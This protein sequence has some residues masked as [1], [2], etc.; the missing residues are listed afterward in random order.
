M[1][2]TIQAATTV[3]SANAN[4]TG[5]PTDN[6]TA[7]PGFGLSRA[8][9]ANWPMDPSIT[10]LNHGSYGLCPRAVSEAQS[11]LRA[12]MERDPVRFFKV[13]LE[14]LMDGVRDRLGAYLNC[15]AADLAPVM[16]A[17]VAL[18]TILHNTPFQAGDE[19]LVTDHE[20]SSGLNELARM[21]PKLGIKVVT[22]KVSFPIYSPREVVDS[23]LAAV[24]PR[25]KLVLISQ[26][27][28][29]TSLIFP[30]EL[31][32]AELNRRNID[33][34]VDGAH[35]PGQIAVDIAALQP[36]YWVG[37]FHKWA[38]APKGTSFMYVRPDKQANFRSVVLSSRA[39]KVRPE[40]KLFL[41]DFDYMGTA[42]Y[43]GLLTIPVA[44]DTMANLLPGGLPALM[45]HNHSMVIQARD[46]VTRITGL[47]PTA[48]DSMTGCMTTLILPSPDAEHAARPTIYDDPMQ[49]AL[50]DR[51]RIQIP[52]WPF[53]TGPGQPGSASNADLRLLRISAQ[54]YNTPDEYQKLGEA[55][56]QELARER[57][58]RRTG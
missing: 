35:A 50:L 16:N 55:L 36:T 5:S 18:A 58:L 51:H 26:I 4:P 19:V 48:P 44:L 8:A 20:Y 7:S 38:S 14:R 9:R 29:A 21:A 1:T 13:D 28:S 53:G 27:T 12:R 40:R 22:A 6:L 52:V 33:V 57:T 41:R 42:D 31:I 10:F 25:T 43:T 23:V 47:Q 3:Q 45:R 54:V 49:D 46:I 32:V 24:T 15:S 17:T 39:D 2:M 11:E 56:V 34:I 30:V 37:S